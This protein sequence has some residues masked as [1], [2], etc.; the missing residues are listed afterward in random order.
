MPDLGPA[1]GALLEI[2]GPLVARALRAFAGSLVG[3][4]VLAVLVAAASWTIASPRSAT[5]GALAVVV[6]LLLFAVV[7][8]LVAGKRAI[9]AA[10]IHAAGSAHL[11]ER[12]MTLVF[13]RL[14]ATE[15]GVAAARAAERLP[16]ADAEA[17]LRRVVDAL[18]REDADGGFVRRRIRRAALERVELVTLAELRVQGAPTGGVELSRVRAALSGRIDGLVVGS[19]EGAAL[20]IT[21]ALL[22]GATLASLLLAFLVRSAALHAAG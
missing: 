18:V 3:G 21:A 19:L 8:F 7:S 16:L 6:T 10:L 5:G 12:A 14:V 11:G 22:G 13:D 20:K 15:H 4:L 1:A 17:K 9:F 2:G